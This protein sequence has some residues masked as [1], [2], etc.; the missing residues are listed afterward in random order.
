MIYAVT[1]SHCLPEVISHGLSKARRTMGS[2][3]KIDQWIVVDHHWP[4]QK[5]LTSKIIT[6]AAL[7]VHGSIIKPEKNLGGVGGFNFAFSQLDIRDDDLILIYD[8]DSN[9]ITHDWF[10]AMI[11]VM[12]EDTSIPYLSLMFRCHLNNRQWMIKEVA[13]H[14]VASDHNP[15]AINVT[16]FRGSVVKNGLPGSEKMWGGLEAAL[17]RLNQKG[18]YLIDVI[19]DSCPIAH[20]P[21]YGRW[22]GQHDQNHFAGNFDEYVRFIEQNG[23]EP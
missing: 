21:E 8:P 9:P 5:E 14:R 3:D 13:G 4:L 15:D 2:F 10:T 16:L 1:L 17:F 7:I 20:P 19:E 12:R 6:Q 23:R 22:K 18:S 11:D